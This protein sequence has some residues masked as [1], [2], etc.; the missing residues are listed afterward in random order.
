MALCHNQEARSH[1]CV[2]YA[3]RRERASFT[4][5]SEFTINVT[6]KNRQSTIIAPGKKVKSQSTITASDI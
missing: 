6:I 4:R 5:V 1:F 3:Q 2:K